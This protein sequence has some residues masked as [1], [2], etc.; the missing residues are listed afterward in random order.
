MAYSDTALCKASVLLD[1]PIPEIRA[2]AAVESNGSG[3][4][5]GTNTPVILYEPFKFGTHTAHKFDGKTTVIKGT[6]YPL[7][8]KGKWSRARAKYGPSSIQHTKLSAAAALNRTAALM[9]CSWGA[10]QVMGENWKSLGYESLQ[11]FINKMYADE[12]GHLD[13]FVRF[14][15]V[16]GLADDLREHRE[17]FFD[18]YN[19][20]QWRQNDYMNKFKRELKKYS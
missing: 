17:S 14:I 13:A 8:L 5:S 2:I 9:S 7:S 10:F 4:Y 19:G 20:S 11:E 16:N 3:F 18:R 15:K 1:V 12:D 6:T